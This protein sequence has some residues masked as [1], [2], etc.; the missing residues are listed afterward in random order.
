MTQA[1]D[2]YHKWLG[3]APKDQPPNHYRLLGIELFEDDCDVIAAA[4]ERQMMHLHSLKLGPRVEPSQ[5]LLNELAAARVCLLKPEEKADY[6]AR[7]RRSLAPPRPGAIPFDGTA[8]TSSRPPIVPTRHDS[9]AG[10]RAG[11][12]A[13]A[14]SSGN[15][16][17]LIPTLAPYKNDAPAPLPALPVAMPV[18]PAAR[19]A[20]PAQSA[21]RPWRAI[22]LAVAAS[23][24]GLAFLVLGGWVA[25]RTAE[26]TGVE[27]PPIELAKAM[28]NSRRT[29]TTNPN[30][31][32]ASQPNRSI[33][34][35]GGA[36]EG[37]DADSA[38]ITPP[39]PPVWTPETPNT[40]RPAEESGPPLMPA[41]AAPFDTGGAA[42]SDKTSSRSGLTEFRGKWNVYFPLPT[43]TGLEIDGDG[44]AVFTSFL[45]NVRRGQL[46]ADGN[47]ALL[48]CGDDVFARLRLEH[49]LLLVDQFNTASGWPRPLGVGAGAR[50]VRADTGQDDGA[51]PIARHVDADDP[52]DDF[53]LH[54]N[55]VSDEFARLTGTALSTRQSYSGPIEIAVVARTDKDNIRLCAYGNA[56]L[57]FNWEAGLDQ[58]RGRRPDGSSFQRQT[59]PLSPDTWYQFRWKITEK[60]FQVF[61]DDQ[62]VFDEHRAYNLRTATPVW[63]PGGVHGSTVDVKSFTVTPLEAAAPPP[64]APAQSWT[65][66]VTHRWLVGVEATAGQ[67]ACTSLRATVALPV[68]WPEQQVKVVEESFSPA[69]LHVSYRMIDS[70]KQMVVVLPRLAKGTQASALLTLDIT[71]RSQVPPT[72]TGVFRRAAASQLPT[73]IL[74]Y[75]RPSPGIEADDRSVKALAAKIWQEQDPSK[76]DW[77]RVEALFD[78]TRNQI[79]SNGQQSQPGALQALRERTS[80]HEGLC[81]LFIALCRAGQVPAR[82]VWMPPDCYPEFCLVDEQGRGC[83]FP[84]R[85]A[86]TREFG[87]ISDRRPIWQKGDNF[88]IPESPREPVGYVE[89]TITAKGRQPQAHY[90][91]KSFGVV[92]DGSR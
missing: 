45:S 76:N 69:G 40:V 39:S 34:P 13:V 42:A 41:P 71:R 43:D 18:M 29:P 85:V 23:A 79:R 51:R 12:M 35:A 28:N 72:N 57:I 64:D 83:W 81:R 36:Q 7:L 6:D 31:V 59:T 92:V 63:I 32:D 49:D 14:I 61:I 67:G 27:R 70:V 38:R 65:R 24:V 25:Y 19:L 80:N 78:W 77:Q 10:S 16:D 21:R 90:V 8:E 17:S 4:A 3:I 2:P 54:G 88:R 33:A 82:T 87:G 5:R 50:A 56:G 44:N 74:Q 48:V 91:R 55:S 86:G 26:P 22:W 84:C 68:D 58:L 47:A 73:E 62:L 60:S 11:D 20:R 75:L 89:P 1:F 46:R 30:H 37:L 15:V 53:D 52:W 9:Q 66:S